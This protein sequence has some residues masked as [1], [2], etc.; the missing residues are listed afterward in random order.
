MTPVE[1]SKQILGL[2][3]H[4][5]P[6][7]LFFYDGGSIGLCPRCIAMHSTFLFMFAAALTF[8]KQTNRL[9]R[10]TIYSLLILLLLMPVD[11]FLAQLHIIT[12]NTFTRL[13]TGAITG[14]TLA[15]LCRYYQQ[16]IGLYWDTRFAVPGVTLLLALAAFTIVSVP[17]YGAITLILALVVTTNFMIVVSILT[18]RIFFIL[19][20]RKRT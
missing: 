3:C 1:L 2:F 17:L 14:F 12:D 19:H 13:I 7:I 15:I 10:Q 11:W 9:N 5:N 8:K 20:F 6:E 18:S 4:Q 16:N